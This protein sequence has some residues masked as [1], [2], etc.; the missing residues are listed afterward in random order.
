M[1]SMLVDTIGPR[2]TGSPAHKRAADCARDTLTKWGLDE[3][4]P[5][6]VRVRPR[7]GRSTSSRSRWSSRA[8]CRSLGYAE[9]WSPSTTGEVVVAA[10]VRRRQVRRRRPRDDRAAQGRGDPAGSRSSRN[11]IAHR[12]RRS[13]RSQPDRAAGAPRAADRRGGMAAAVARQAAARQAR[14]PARRRRRRRRS[15]RTQAR[16]SL[17]KPSRGD[18]RHAC[19]CRPPPR[20]HD[21]HAAEDRARRRALQHRRAAAA[22]EHA[23]EAARE[24]AGALP[25]RIGNSY[26][27][28][29]EIPGTD[30]ALKTQIVMLGAHLDSWHTGTGATDNADGAVVV[31][32]AF[33]ILKAI[34]AAPK[35]TLRLA[36]WS[37]EEEGLLGSQAYVRDHLDGDAHKAERD[38]D[39]RVLQHRSRQGPDLRLVPREQR[40]RSSRSS[41]RGSRRSR[42]WAP[43]ATCRRASATPIT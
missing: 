24:R 34:G 3:R 11:F 16:P 23:G 6:A 27:V 35:R 38:E 12:S 39:R 43:C 13:R 1:F 10:V 18:A 33:R 14:R 8:T 32:E 28:L 2:L 41:T 7:L 36:L 19:S 15:C 21:G 37:G 30:P 22:A 29:A 4:A 25:R 17:L 40:R 31:M 42:I 26:N 5:R 20:E 9:A